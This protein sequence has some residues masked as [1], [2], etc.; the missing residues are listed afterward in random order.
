LSPPPEEFLNE[1][2]L[3][4][5]ERVG[6]VDLV[7]GIPS[8][9]SARTVGQVVKAALAGLGKHFPESR[10]AIVNSDGGS[11]DGTREVVAATEL[12]P[13]VALRRHPTPIAVPRLSTLYQGVPGKGSA[14]RTIF[15]IA[16]RLGAKAC[17]VVDSDLRSITPEWIELLLGPVLFHGFD[18]V[19]PLYRR[20]KYD[21]TIT[22]SLVYPLTRSLYGRR[23]RQPI[24][25]DF[26][27]SAVMRDRFL[28]RDVWTTD[29]ARFGIDIWMTTLALSTTDRICQVFLGAKLHDAKDPGQHLAGMLAQVASSIFDRMVGDFPIWSKVNASADVPTFGFEFDVGLDPVAVNV[30]RMVATY[31]QGLRDLDAI[32]RSILQPET[33][34]AVLSICGAAAPSFT[35]P[36]EAWVA[37]VHDFAVSFASRTVHRD[38][39]LGCLFPLYL[40]RTASWVN[41]AAAY[42][43]VEVEQRIEALCRSFDE[44]KP[45]LVARWPAGVQSPAGGGAS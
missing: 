15:E 41:E 23:V 11:K 18:Y 28:E 5:I 13:E 17:A 42:G 39:L 1:D 2:A 12:P 27:F 22:N 44:A 31:E 24:G 25:G 37:V 19:A 8:F 20:H 40:G 4:F 43:A 3:A 26:G 35:M 10:A 16:R 36:P 14:F 29:V 45:D 38:H 6:A 33:H 30:E 9:N 7:V 34:R 21:G 32:Y